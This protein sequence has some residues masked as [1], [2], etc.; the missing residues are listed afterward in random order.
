MKDFQARQIVRKI[1]KQIINLP[2]EGLVLPYRKL[3]KQ[4][5]LMKIS[6]KGVN[7]DLHF[8]LFNDC[9]F[10]CTKTIPDNRLKLNA[11]LPIDHIFHVKNIDQALKNINNADLNLNEKFGIENF[12]T[13]SF[14]IYASNKSLI[15][16]AN[17]EKLKDE[18]I[19]QLQNLIIEKLQLFH[20]Q[21][22]L[23]QP[24]LAAPLLIPDHWSDTCQAKDCGKKFNLIRRRH[25]CRWCGILMCGDCGKYKLASKT[26]LNKILKPVCKDC[27]ESYGKRYRAKTTASIYSGDDTG[28]DEDEWSDVEDLDS[29]GD[30][31]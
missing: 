30:K 23:L 18:W 2:K 31:K 29:N 13:R 27:Y 1:E 4:G 26:N 17:N 11:Q 8:I 22:I 16:Y 9:L 15:V 6:R 12:L 5:S 21:Q 25:H 24:E 20:S 10:Y 14:A 7:M 19:T 28:D 3:I